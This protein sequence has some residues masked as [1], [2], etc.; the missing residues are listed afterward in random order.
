MAYTRVAGKEKGADLFT[1]PLSWEEMSSHVQRLEGEFVDKEAMA[2]VNVFGGGTL[3]PTVLNEV[4]KTAEALKVRQ[5][6]VWQR[7]DMQSRTT[8][9]SMRGGPSW[10]RVLAR[11]TADANT[12]E[13]LRSEVAQG[14]T[15]NTEHSLLQEGPRDI[16]IALLFEKPSCGQSVGGQRK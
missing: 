12:G 7:G 1:K 8:K 5:P 4:K 10:D 16:V 14:I 15:R 6:I 3:A 11:I 2:E 13:I 9:T